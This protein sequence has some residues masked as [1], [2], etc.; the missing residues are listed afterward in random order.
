MIS[1]DFYGNFCGCIFLKP[2]NE[3]CLIPPC[4][5]LEFHFSNKF[6]HHLWTVQTESE[7]SSLY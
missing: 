3:V 5:S 1:L 7:N 2:K 4:V 6:C